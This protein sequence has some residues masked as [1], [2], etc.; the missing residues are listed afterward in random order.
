MG[1][2]SPMKHPPKAADVASASPRRRLAHIWAK[3]THEHYVE[4][5]WV[6]R[7]LFDVED[8]DR[9]EPVLDPCAG[10]GRI[11][12]AAQAAGYRAL[13]ADIVD[14][15][16]PNCEVQDFL[17]RRCMPA[18]GAINPPFNGA[19]AIARH[20]FEIGAHK[21][22]LL[23]PIARLNAAHWLRDLPLK[24]IWLLTPRPSMP[25]GSYITAGLKPQGGRVDFTWLIFE[26]GFSGRAETAWLHRDR[27][28]S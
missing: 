19:E 2:D 23:F 24:R 16:C 28:T 22:A 4:P 21:L 13:A 6:G 25:P 17:E 9:G 3:E 7:R 14:R 27:G 11:P 20:A 12:E 15:G 10:F 8:F 18:S 5:H 26:R 1:V